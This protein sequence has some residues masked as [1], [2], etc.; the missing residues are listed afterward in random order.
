MHYISWLQ[1]W[2]RDTKRVHY[3]QIWLNTVGQDSINRR[4]QD[5]ELREV[6]PV[7]LADNWTTALKKLRFFRV[8]WKIRNW[9]VSGRPQN[10]I[11]KT[12]RQFRG[13]KTCKRSE[14]SQ[15]T[16]ESQKNIVSGRLRNTIPATIWQFRDSRRSKNSQN[17][18]ESRKVRVVLMICRAL[19]WTSDQKE[20]H[21]I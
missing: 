7:W 13:P 17:T 20:A 14:N 8:T 15:N 18:W 5:S 12:I 1:Q 6:N 11:P 4:Q 10:P 19:N 21:L 16:R 2:N 3:N 9:P